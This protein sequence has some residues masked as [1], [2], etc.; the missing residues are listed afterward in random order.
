MRLAEAESEEPGSG[1]AA[2]IRRDIEALDDLSRFALPLIDDL[3]A[4]PALAVWGEWL[5]RLSALAPRALRHPARVLEL[6]ADLRPMASVGPLTLAEVRQVLVPRLSTLER[7]PPRQRAGRVFIGTAD[8]LRG[9]SFTSV[10]ITGLAERV[11]PQRAR[12]DPLLLDALRRSRSCLTPRTRLLVEDDRVLAERLLLRVAA[13]AARRTP[14]P[15]RTREWTCRRRA[16]ACRRSMPSTSC[17]RSPAS[18]PTTRPSS[19]TPPSPPA[20]GSPGRRPTSRRPRST[21]GSTTSPCSVR[22]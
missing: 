18:S 6:L 21:P 16:R 14:L 7:E 9:R 2:A 3:A 4:L 1:Q 20:P 11:F 10:F 8:H 12:Q 22:C 19:A 13:G 17:A 5:D 15:R